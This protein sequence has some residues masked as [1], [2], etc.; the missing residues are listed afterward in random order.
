MFFDKKIKK[1]WSFQLKKISIITKFA[2]IIKNFF[3][4]N[5]LFKEQKILSN[6][7]N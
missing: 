3:I 4:L 6:L 1:T 5:L 7:W 2:M